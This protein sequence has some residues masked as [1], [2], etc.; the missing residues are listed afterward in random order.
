MKKLNVLAAI[1]GIL[2]GFGALPA[3]A[4]DKSL[5][6][7]SLEGEWEGVGQ[8][9]VPVT[10]FSV[11]IDGHASFKWIPDGGYLRTSLTGDKLFFTYSDSGH[12][13]HNKVTDSVS[14]E[15]WDNTGRHARYFG[16]ATGNTVRGNRIY[17]K[18][19][20]EV[21]IKMVTI[22][23]IDFKLQVTEPDGDSF[24]KATFSLWRMKK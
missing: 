20:Y 2:V 6:I 24:D 21:L 23:S 14:W 9:L 1:L 19:R 17:N 22:D 3:A 5:D 8:F 18:D 15:V 16:E 12:L 4:K 7:R 13:I 10:N 11:D